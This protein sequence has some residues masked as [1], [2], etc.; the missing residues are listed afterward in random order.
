M[1]VFLVSVQALNE[2]PTLKGELDSTREPFGLSSLTANNNSLR[3][4]AD[5][6]ESTFASTKDFGSK[7][8]SDNLGLSA[9]I[10]G[11]DKKNKY[12]VRSKSF[13]EI[14]KSCYISCC[15]IH[16]ITH[17]AFTA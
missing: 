15:I 3:M 12:D 13:S 16:L 6:L 8:F 5:S 14:H 1:D 2:L 17:S 7:R 11:G 4:T 9:T 10:P